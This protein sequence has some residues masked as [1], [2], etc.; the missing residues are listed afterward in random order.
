MEK[1]KITVI[2]QVKK[3]GLLKSAIRKAKEIVRNDEDVNVYILAEK[4]DTSL[5]HAEA[6]YDK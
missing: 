5:L 4:V 6:S 2:I 3:I 1:R